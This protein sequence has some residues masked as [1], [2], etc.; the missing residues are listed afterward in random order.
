MLT[1]RTLQAQQA[2]KAQQ[3]NAQHPNQHSRCAADVMLLWHE[4]IRAYLEGS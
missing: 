2:Y 3:M 1:L 4:R